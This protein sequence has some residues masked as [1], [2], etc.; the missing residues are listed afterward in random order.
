MALYETVTV[1]IP[2]HLFSHFLSAIVFN[3]LYS[4]GGRSKYKCHSYL[5]WCIVL[6][7]RERLG[8]DNVNFPGMSFQSRALF[9][10]LSKRYVVVQRHS[11]TVTKCTEICWTNT[12][13]GLTGK[14]VRSS[15]ENPSGTGEE[16]RRPFSFTDIYILTKI[17]DLTSAQLGSG[18]DRLSSVQLL[19]SHFILEFQN[20]G[21]TCMYAYTFILVFSIGLK[22]ISIDCSE[23]CH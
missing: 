17:K 11:A 6:C 1:F 13:I 21:C 9:K 2:L 22:K 15:I 4:Q 3:K 5:F 23:R 12:H 19:I 14:A 20:S 16:W 7:L 8:E 10:N 18:I